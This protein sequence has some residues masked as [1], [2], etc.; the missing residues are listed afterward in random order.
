MKIMDTLTK[1]GTKSLLF[2]CHQ[3]VLHPVFV[4]AAWVRLYGWPDGR[5]VLFWKL[6]LIS[7][8]HDWGY[9]GCATMDGPAGKYHPALGA[10]IVY[11]LTG[12]GP[13]ARMCLYHS[14]FLA[15]LENDTPSVLCWVDKL[16]TAL[17]PSWLWA[18]LARASGEGAEYMADKRYEIHR[19][20]EKATIAGLIGF[21]K[22]LKEWAKKAAGY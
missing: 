6:A 5:S 13:M 12:D 18:I 8:V 21:H 16:G 20:G 7:I 10:L 2:G 22:R 9:W 3:F 19:P 1:R 11:R 15:W 14:R 17:Y 4:F